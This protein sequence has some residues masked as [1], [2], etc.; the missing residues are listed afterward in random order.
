MALINTSTAK[1]MLTDFP[2]GLGLAIFCL[3]LVEWLKDPQKQWHKAAWAAG[4]LGLTSL[5]RPHVMAVLL[6]F[7]AGILLVYLPGWRR[8]LAIASLGLLAF[9]ASITPWVFF[10]GSEVSVIDLYA[11]RIR[12]VID[13]RYRP[14]EQEQIPALPAKP[15]LLALAFQAGQ[16]IEVPFAVNHFLN[17]LQ[18]SAF[19]LPVS[20]QFIS[21]RETTKDTESVWQTAWGG[22][23]SSRAAVM[24]SLGLALAALGIGAAAQKSAR[25]GMALPAVFVIYAG[26]NA[27]ARTSGGRYVVPIDWILF[28]F[29]GLGL[30]VLVEASSM[31]FKRPADA[32]ESVGKGQPAANAPKN[33]H[34]AVKVGGV[35]V[36]FGLIGGLIP[37]AQELHPPRYQ[38]MGQEALL[39]AIGGFLPQLGIQRQAAETFLQDENAVILQGMALYPRFFAQGEGVPSWK[40]YSRAEY[41]RTIFVLIGPQAKHFVM[42][43]PG[44][45]PERLPHKSDVI[46]LAC[47]R[48]NINDD[49]LDAL[50]V[51]LPGENLTYAMEPQ[52]PLQ[53]PVAEPV[54]NNNKTCR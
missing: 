26:A 24:L 17:N 19:G 25:A 4:T 51:V 1:H 44:L 36:A 18:T 5:L 10:G 53:C 33:A 3:F 37:L 50:V 20:P 41:P 28:L 16:P 21:L 13:Q 43:L 31:F 23:L 52:R 47:K 45:V 35:M 30:W 42:V 22:D 15:G 34:W 48:E 29:L 6:V 27:L 11:T 7:M 38:R 12:G 40:P 9:F 54:C 49:I 39:D 8:G 32:G 14:P 46:V 2:T